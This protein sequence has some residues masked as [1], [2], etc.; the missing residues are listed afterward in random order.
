[1]KPCIANVRFGPRAA[2]HPEPP[3]V[4]FAPIADIQAHQ[5]AA[6]CFAGSAY[7]LMCPVSDYAWSSNDF[8]Q[9]LLAGPG[10]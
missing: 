6:V 9:K 7:I 5:I 2:I 10:I 8:R 3:K 4:N 1:M